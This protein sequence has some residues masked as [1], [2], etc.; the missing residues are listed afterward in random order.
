M[1]Y[2]YLAGVAQVVLIAAALQPLLRSGGESAPAPPESG[3]AWPPA[4]RNWLGA[5]RLP[6]A[7]AGGVGVPREWWHALQSRQFGGR[8][9]LAPPMGA[10]Y[11][12]T[13][14]L[15]VLGTQTIQLTV[16]S[17][18]LMRLELRGAIL[19]DDTVAYARAP[20]GKLVFEFSDATTRML[21]RFR[22]SFLGADYT[23]GN[24]RAT[25][26]VSPPLMPGAVI[27]Q[28]RRQACAG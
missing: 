14:W 2:H 12:R 5:L 4:V 19:L 20:S 6:R 11:A 24:D 1:I 26:S 8:D 22:T 21:R 25:F 3:Q 16:L 28:L 7:S 23:P 27:V 15:P 18:V 10:V 13:L 17:K 9:E